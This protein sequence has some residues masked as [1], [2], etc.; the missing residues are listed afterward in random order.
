MYIDTHAHLT[1]GA[2]DHDR[3]ELIKGLAAGG[4][5]KIIEISCDPKDFPV[6]AALAEQ[7]PGIYL[8]FGIHP[9]FAET[10]TEGDIAALEKYL[11]H[12]K[13]VALGEIGLDYYWKPYNREKQLELFRRQL[14]M[15]IERDMPVSM[16]IREAY[17]DCMEVLES[18][19]GRIK[20][21]M[22][23]F[24]GSAEIA[25]R[26][27]GLGLYIA[28]GGAL[29]FRSKKAR[30]PAPP[31]PLTGFSPK[32]IVPTWPRSPTGESATTPAA[33]PRYAAKWLR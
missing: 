17:G 20:G 8:A 19:G 9:E 13:C 30:R 22:H 32:P 15:A 24:S 29:T 1:D 16:H 27:A 4:I 10:Y 25:E 3:Q 21:V 18:Y 28:F 12:P 33:Y 6:S 7:N 23:C 11:R 14:D 31:L 26:C 2:F 5:G